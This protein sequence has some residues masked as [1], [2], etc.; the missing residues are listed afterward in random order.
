MLERAAAIRGPHRRCAATSTSRPKTRDV[1]DPERL[2]QARCSSTRRRGP[3]WGRCASRGWWTLPAA[4]HGGRPL[5][6]VGLP[7]AG[8]SRRTAACASTIFSSTPAARRARHHL[9]RRSRGPQ[10]EPPSDHA[11]VWADSGRGRWGA[12]AGPGAAG[13]TRC[14]SCLAAATAGPLA[15]V[16][17]P[18][19]KARRET[20]H[21]APAPARPQP[22]R[23][24]THPQA[25][26]ITLAGGGVGKSERSEAID[27]PLARQRA[28]RE[29]GGRG[30]LRSA[31]C[32]A[33]HRR[34][35]VDPPSLPRGTKR[36]AGPRAR[37]TPA[38]DYI[39]S[40]PSIDT[41][42]PVM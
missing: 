30:V 34:S 4:P 38:R 25:R 13:G 37:P 16:G 41:T 15:T 20:P 39:V 42:E 12:L 9:R 22:A 23:P 26:A 36:S 6:L 10:G 21:A 8:A 35:R 19:G 33:A 31:P 7:Q 32:R 29:W 3:R 27:G 5:L 1:H 40:P 17:A 2:A 28:A 14:A 11:A 24:T 18:L